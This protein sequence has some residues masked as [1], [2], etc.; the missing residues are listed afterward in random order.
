MERNSQLLGANRS[1]VGLSV[2][3]VFH[4]QI[5][6]CTAVHC[7]Q[8]SSAWDYVRARSNPLHWWPLRP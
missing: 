8:L 2:G 6:E 7:L 5:S 3:N 4:L 1:S